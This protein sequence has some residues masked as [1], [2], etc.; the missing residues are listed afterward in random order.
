MVKTEVVESE[1]MVVVVLKGYRVEFELGHTFP[2]SI[3]RPPSTIH[4]SHASRTG[5]RWHSL[6]PFFFME[7][8]WRLLLS[9]SAISACIPFLV[10]EWSRRRRQALEESKKQLAVTT[11]DVLSVYS[12]QSRTIVTAD[13]DPVA[14]YPRFPSAHARYYRANDKV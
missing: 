8:R 1:K 14:Q 7:I 10:C 6:F 11:K 4:R 13:C 5:A 3:H 9:W 12:V 2:E